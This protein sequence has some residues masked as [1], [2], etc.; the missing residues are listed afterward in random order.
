[1]RPFRVLFYNAV[2]ANVE[3]ETRYPHLGFAYI[4]AF[5][6]KTIQ[7]RP[8]QFLID[9]RHFEK[10]LSEFKPDLIGISAVSQN[11]TLACTYAQKAAA[12]GIPCIFGGIHVSVLPQ[13]MPKTAFAACLGESE[14]TFSD[15]LQAFLNGEPEEQKKSIPGLAYWDGDTL[16]FTKDRPRIMDLDSIPIPARD[17]IPVSK[18]T[19]MF[20]S[21]G[22]PYRCSFCASS[23]Y[24]DSVR[25]FSAEYVVHE[26]E[27]LVKTYDVEF[28]SFFD[29]LFA[30][31]RDRVEAIIQLLEERGLRGRVRFSMNCRANIVDR[32]LCE[33]LARMGVVSV[34]L[35]LESGDEETLKFLKGPSVTVEDNQRAVEELKRV[36]IAANA[37]FVIGSPQET[38]EQMMRTYDFI[39]KS[40]LDLFDVYLLTP[41]PGTPVWETAKMQGHVSDTMPDWSILDINAYRAPEKAIIVSEVCSKEEVLTIYR[42]FLRL[43]WYWN[44]MHVWRHPLRGM[45]PRIIWKTI[46][47]RFSRWFHR[48]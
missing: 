5:A 21:R 4:A 38:T 17:L 41:F 12:M 32:E 42:R 43:R 33:M 39:R 8:L 36:G 14:A 3:T 29:D 27:E 26:I 19:Y 28:I 20:T 47:D 7:D 15:V 18:H 48:S 31:K 35:G 25:F 1:M 10:H 44:I 24:W 23:R 11:F 2:N 46:Q 13:T 37:S 30:A 45:L 40:R 34:G 9:D 16:C 6:R 22:C